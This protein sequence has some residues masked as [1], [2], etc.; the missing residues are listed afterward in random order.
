[1]KYL[2]TL[3]IALLF[4]SAC[5]KESAPSKGH[6]LKKVDFSDSFSNQK[7]EYDAQERLTLKEQYDGSVLDSKEEYSYVQDSVYIKYCSFYNNTWNTSNYVLY[8][9]GDSLIHR[10]L[11]DPSEDIDLFI[12]GEYCG[13][14][15]IQRLYSDFTLLSKVD[16]EYS[17][18]SCNYK[19]YHY[20]ESGE[21]SDT[22]E[23][24]L[25]GRN[26]PTPSISVNGLE[27]AH[28]GR[29]NI[30]KET[31]YHVTEGIVLE[32]NYS[33]L[34]NELGYPTKITEKAS[35]HSASYVYY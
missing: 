24:I 14:I 7:F 23:F 13:V 31:R 19:E 33:I 28:P 29:G 16:I 6:L 9:S 5:T 12:Y 17:E 8:T 11:D 3:L 22:R 35:Q 27:F 4:L 34:Y 30:L 15:S 20:S 25:D 21:L 32:R 18:N 2:S 10:S 1:M 26:R